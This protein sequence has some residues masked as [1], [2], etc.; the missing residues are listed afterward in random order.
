MD[1]FTFS[2]CVLLFGYF[3]LWGLIRITEIVDEAKYNKLKQ[4]EKGEAQ[5]S[6]IY[7]NGQ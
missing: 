2:G 7:K 3:G 4:K 1:L 6:I 5:K